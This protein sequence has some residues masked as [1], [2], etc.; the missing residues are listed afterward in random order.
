[1]QGHGAAHAVPH[2]P[3][4]SS[5]IHFVSG[6]EETDERFRV[7]VGGGGGDGVVEGHQHRAGGLVLKAGAFG[8]HGRPRVPVEGVDHQNR[9]ARTSQAVGH[10]PERGAQPPDVRPYDHR[11]VLALSGMHEVRIRLAI[12]RGDPN[13]ATRNRQRVGGEGE[14]HCYRRTRSDP[15]ELAP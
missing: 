14:H 13:V 10:L 1:M 12:R 6:I 11:R 8:N 2:G 5:R 15:R 3:D 4:P 7:H 9:V